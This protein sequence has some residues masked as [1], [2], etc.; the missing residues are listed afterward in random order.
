MPCHW[1]AYNQTQK[2]LRW[3]G[4]KITYSSLCLWSF[5]CQKNLL[6]P[7]ELLR[8][9]SIYQVSERHRWHINICAAWVASVPGRS[10][11]N[12]PNLHF[13]VMVELLIQKPVCESQLEWTC[14][15]TKKMW[16]VKRKELEVC[17]VILV[18]FQ[19]LK[20]LCV[21]FSW[22][23]EEVLLLLLLLNLYIILQPNIS[24]SSSPCTPSCKSS[25]YSP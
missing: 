7:H 9:I 1:L 23:L 18:T 11:R 17:T 8:A 12:A 20:H 6:P 21:L 25:P 5:K 22:V 16:E 19:I 2:Y 15:W 13:C 3:R 14:K 10:W 4:N 24:S